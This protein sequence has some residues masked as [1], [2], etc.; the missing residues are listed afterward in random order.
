MYFSPQAPNA[1]SHSLLTLHGPGGQAGD[2]TV[3]PWFSLPAQP[4]HEP[5]LNP[6]IKP[7]DR[8]KH[9][10]IKRSPEQ[11]SR[12]VVSAVDGVAH[13]ERE[14]NRNLENMFLKV[15]LWIDLQAMVPKV[16]AEVPSQHLSHDNS[17]LFLHYLTSRQKLSLG[18]LYLLT[19]I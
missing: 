4:H 12:N 9:V 2:G 14:I 15:S 10:S 13:G 17:V 8:Q 5:H 6:V 7:S 16:G 19:N 3:E 11:L 18:N 1:V